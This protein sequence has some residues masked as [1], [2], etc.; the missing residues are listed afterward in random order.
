[1]F[2]PVNTV[3]INIQSITEAKMNHLRSCAEA[4]RKNL[5]K[6]IP[7]FEDYSAEMYFGVFDRNFFRVVEF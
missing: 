6:F 2:V 1:M 4:E 5:R 7:Y 3:Q